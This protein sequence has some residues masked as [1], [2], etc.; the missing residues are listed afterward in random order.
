LKTGVITTEATRASKAATDTGVP[1]YRQKC[2]EGFTL[3]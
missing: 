2:D 3:A 1:K